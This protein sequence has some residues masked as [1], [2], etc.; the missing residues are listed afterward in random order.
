MAFFWVNATLPLTLHRFKRCAGNRVPDCICCGSGLFDRSKRLG[1]LHMR[2]YGGLGECR[3]NPPTRTYRL[4]PRSGAPP[5]I[6]EKT[7]DHRKSHG[8]IIGGKQP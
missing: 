1:S 3:I 4:E 8:N 7:S 5:R 6:F 2:R